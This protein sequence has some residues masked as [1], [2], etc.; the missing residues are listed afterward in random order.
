MLCFAAVDPQNEYRVAV[1]MYA[2]TMGSSRVQV[3]MMLVSRAELGRAAIPSDNFVGYLRNDDF[4]SVIA[5]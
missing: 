4:S 2:K 5:L 1:L 3:H